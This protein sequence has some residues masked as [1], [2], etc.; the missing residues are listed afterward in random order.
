MG[1][2]DLKKNAMLSRGG[3]KPLLVEKT[4]SFDEFID[5]ATLYAMG[6][7]PLASADNSVASVELVKEFP[8]E[9]QFGAKLGAQIIA[10]NVVSLHRPMI[11]DLG[12]GDNVSGDNVRGDKRPHYRNATFSLSEAAI[13]HLATLA[14][15]SEM[16]KS[17]MLRLLIEQHYALPTVLRQIR[18]PRI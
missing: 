15:E 11:L 18:K 3:T 10:S 7:T 17:K 6:A 8:L 4:L 2:S 9:G 14:G 13:T 5:A 12:S 16:S 1:L